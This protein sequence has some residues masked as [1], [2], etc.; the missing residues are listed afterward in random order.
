MV[1]HNAEP[2]YFVATVAEDE[3]RQP[4][5]VSSDKF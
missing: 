5:V 4:P 3:D 2:A 1:E